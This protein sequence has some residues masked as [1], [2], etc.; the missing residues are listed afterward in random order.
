MPSHSVL[1]TLLHVH[2]CLAPVCLAFEAMGASGRVH[3]HRRVDTKE[4]AKRLARGHGLQAGLGGEA[5][6]EE[7]R[8]VVA[9]QEKIVGVVR[10]LP[11]L[12]SFF[13]RVAK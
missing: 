11:F 9:C 5:V 6:A 7:N 13:P 3:L 2:G 10:G 12:G 1:D 4:R 8:H